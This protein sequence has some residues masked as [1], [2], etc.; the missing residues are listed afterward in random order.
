MINWL[1]M[2]NCVTEYLIVRFTTF[3]CERPWLHQ[4]CHLSFCGFVLVSVIVISFVRSVRQGQLN[5]KSKPEQYQNT[6]VYVMRFQISF[7]LGLLCNASN[8]IKHIRFLLTLLSI[9]L[10][11]YNQNH[12]WFV[13]F[14][15][16]W[17]QPTCSGYWSDFL[18]IILKPHD[19]Q[20]SN[21]KTI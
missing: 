6:P 7:F 8:C 5:V 3:L 16:R 10:P 21:L 12:C 15:R 13:C 11:C 17:I 19:K 4:L 20:N 9:N 18:I 14:L 1:L 2:L